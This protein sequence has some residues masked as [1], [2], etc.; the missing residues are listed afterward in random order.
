MDD[1][2]GYK[3]MWGGLGRLRSDF[4]PQGLEFFYTRYEKLGVGKLDWLSGTFSINSQRMGRF[5]RACARPTE[6]S[7]TMSESTRSV[8]P[9]RRARISQAAGPRLWQRDL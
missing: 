6:S 5:V 3:D 9:C 7:R 8:T 1:V 2:R 4:Q